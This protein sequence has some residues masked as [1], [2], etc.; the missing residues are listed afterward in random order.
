MNGLLKFLQIEPDSIKYSICLYL[1]KSNRTA[2]CIASLLKESVFIFT[3][4][5]V[6]LFY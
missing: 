6:Q 4:E 1:L 3:H 2:F 5:M